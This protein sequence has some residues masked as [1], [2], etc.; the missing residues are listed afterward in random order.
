MTDISADLGVSIP[1][2]QQEFDKIITS[3]GLQYKAPEEA[4]NLLIDAT[5][6]GREYG[7]LCFHDTQKII[8]FAEIKTETVRDLR[9]GLREL[10]EA[11]YKIKSV[12]IDGRRGYYNAIKKIL[13]PVPVQM[14]L[15]HQKAIIRRYITDK[16]KSLCGQDL[17]RLMENLCK[18][19]QQNF[20]DDFYKLTEIHHGTLN[21]RNEKGGYTHTS[22]R[23]AFRSLQTNMPY[24]FAYTDAQS[25]K[26]PPTI[27]HLEGLFGHLKEKINIHR[28][29][30]KSR[31]KKAIKFFLKF[32]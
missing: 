11:K 8:Y 21:Q 12:T 14:C 3:E 7:F 1:K 6:F 18:E 4:I 27:N 29:L 22:L 23:S 5:F 15:F 19:N 31:K 20:I 16:P 2:L 13:G 10:K 24:I 17:K 30:N 9:S 26:I 28:G 32:F 25:L